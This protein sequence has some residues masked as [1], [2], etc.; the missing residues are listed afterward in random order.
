MA[1]REDEEAD[2]SLEWVA[3]DDA[4]SMVLSGDIVNATAVSGIL[5]L[6]AADRTDTQLR[7]PDSPWRDKPHAFADR[8]AGRAST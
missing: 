6:S 1:E 2:M 4:V 3:L 8:K 5:A 7:T